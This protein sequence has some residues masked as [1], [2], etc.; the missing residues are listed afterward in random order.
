MYKSEGL[1][2]DSTLIEIKALYDSLPEEQI[3]RYYN[4][5]YLTQRTIPR[6]K[7]ITEFETEGLKIHNQYFL[8][9]QEVGETIA[10]GPDVMHSVSKVLKGNRIVLVTWYE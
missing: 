8:E 9:K 7:F 5:F 1:L 6:D 3:K 10:Y 4:L 2:K